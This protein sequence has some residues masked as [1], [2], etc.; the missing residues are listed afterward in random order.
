MIKHSP[1]HQA[2]AAVLLSNKLLRRQP[3]W[4]PTAV[5]QT[6]MTEPML[7]GCV[8]DLRSL[9]SEAEHNSL[10]AVRKKFSH[11]KY[12]EVAKQSFL[13]EV[14]NCAFFGDAPQ[15]AGKPK[16]GSA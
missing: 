16:P 5:K 12:G 8:K 14:S 15:I 7:K 4:T 9:L 10:Q 2:A 1:S 13:K 6:E 11:A 3:V